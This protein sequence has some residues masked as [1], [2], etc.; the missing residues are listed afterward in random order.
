[1][2][3]AGTLEADVD[4]SDTYSLVD[5]DDYDCCPACSLGL[6][7]KQIPG[8]RILSDAQIVELLGHLPTVGLRPPL[9]YGEHPPEVAANTLGD[10]TLPQ[11][12][13]R[14]EI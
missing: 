8:E 3:E 4:I 10:I 2:A 5:V 7:P 11:T 6:E 9:R 14:P 1:M 13:A 12:V